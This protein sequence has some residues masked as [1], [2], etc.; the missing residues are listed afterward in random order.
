LLNIKSYDNLHIKFIDFQKQDIALL[1]KVARA[2][3]KSENIKKCQVNFIMLSD[4]EIKKLNTKYR[5]VR[6]ITDVISFLVVPELFIGDIYISE[7]SSQR[8]A[9]RYN[10]TWRQELAYLV[11]HG[12]LHLCGYTDY[13]AVNKTKMFAKQDKIFKCFFCQD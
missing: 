10:N 11:I 1:Q 9:K 6:R 12:L 8:Q 2:V 3:L 13:D 4:Q 7:N 5:K